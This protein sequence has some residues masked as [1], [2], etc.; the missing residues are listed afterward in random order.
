M[1]RTAKTPKKK[2]LPATGWSEF[3]RGGNE[4]TGSS[5]GVRRKQSGEGSVSASLEKRR[6]Q[7]RLRR[8]RKKQCFHCRKFGHSVAEC[9]EAQQ[10]GVGQCFKC[11]S[12]EHTSKTCRAKLTDEQGDFPFAKCYICGEMG[13]LSKQCSEN[14]RGIYPMGGCCHLCGSVEH[15]RSDCPENKTAGV[16][17]QDKSMTLKQWTDHESADAVV[18]EDA[19]A[20]APVKK[21]KVKGKVVRF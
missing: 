6:E 11:G 13:H 9:S 7:R 14:P 18:E 2:F 8:S 1:T 19:E 15:K 21:Q 3:N 20:M 4:A 17:R 10:Q 12:S 16:Q 5:Q